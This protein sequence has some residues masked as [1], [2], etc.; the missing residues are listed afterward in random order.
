LAEQ[1]LLSGSR[2]KYQR[3]KDWLL[4][5]M[6]AGK[7]KSGDAIP[8]ERALAKMLGCGVHT[9][10]QAL[11]ELKDEKIIHRTRGRGTF[12]NAPLKSARQKLDVYGLILPEVC[13][14]LYPALIKGFVEASVGTSHQV[15]ICDTRLDL[16]L[17]SDVILQL[18]DKNVAG[19]AIVPTIEPMPAYQLNALK[20]RQ[21]PVVF[22][23]RRPPGLVAPL[24]CWG[25][26]EAG[27]M[28]AQSLIERGHR[29]MALVGAGRYEVTEGYERGF[30][31][32]LA[33]QGLDLPEHRIYYHAEL[34]RS[35]APDEAHRALVEMLRKPDRPTGVFC[36]DVIEG[37]RLYIEAIEMGLRIPRDLSIV[38]FGGAWRNG[39]ISERL[40]AVTVDEIELGRRAALMLEKIRAGRQPSTDQ[41]R[42]VMPLGFSE[43]ETLGPPQ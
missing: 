20:S 23:H 15:L 33:Q 14:S 25:W 28:V 4:G 5:Q 17:Q 36:S 2:L 24:I 29:R 9:I 7:L 3:A 32:A 34:A 6:A 19:V 40:A 39:A 27:R 43:G 10:R 1:V 31:A 21:M 18:I 26:E 41:Q 38:G 37:E 22:C 13:G 12:I 16:R 30:R 8:S 42:I 35:A 11:G